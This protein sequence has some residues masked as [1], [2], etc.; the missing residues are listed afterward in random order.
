MACMTPTP[1]QEMGNLEAWQHHMLCLHV[2]PEPSTLDLHGE[3][4]IECY[5]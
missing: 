5:I 4:A 3:A 1:P 2:A